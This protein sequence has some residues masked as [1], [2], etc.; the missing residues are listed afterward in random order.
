[1]A[2]KEYHKEK[3]KKLLRDADV[4][5]WYS[6]LAKGS[7]ILADVYLRALGRFCEQVKLTPKQFV[8][9]PLKK[10]EDVAQDFIDE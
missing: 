5:R 6:N 4:K 8:T 1:M 7:N 9:M 3:Y 2:F 10:M